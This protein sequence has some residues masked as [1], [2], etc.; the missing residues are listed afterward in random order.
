MPT[1]H[2]LDDLL[3]LRQWRRH[4]AGN[5]AQKYGGLGGIILEGEPGL[6][7]TELAIKTLLDHG[8]VRVTDFEAPANVANAF[9]SIPVNLAE[10]QKE[11]LLLKA[12]HEGAV[13]IIDEINSSPMMERLLNDLLM[14][15]TPNGEPPQ[16][17]GFMLI[18]TQNPITMAGRRAQS[19][20]LARRNI[21]EEVRPYPDN[22][23]KQI[24]VNK[25]LHKG[26]AIAINQAF[27]T[28]Q[29]KAKAMNLSPVPTFRDVI[30]LANKMLRINQSLAGLVKSS[31]QKV[32]FFKG[33]GQKGNLPVLPVKVQG[34]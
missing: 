5:E 6:G 27:N 30:N 24:L 14:G 4:Q 34:P 23:M 32:G 11:A 22:E 3:H 15:K 31:L 18:G 17:P 20:A 9:Y 26:Q 21:T 29:Q 10:S 1:R 7:K 19:T 12:F 13:V 8:Y 33:F 28:N 16:N 25:G 2:L